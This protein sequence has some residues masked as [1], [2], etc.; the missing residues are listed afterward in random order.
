M[1]KLGGT[2]GSVVCCT[3]DGCNWNA[4]TAQNN[5]NYGD[6]TNSWFFIP[7]IVNWTPIIL[8]IIFGSLLLICPIILCCICC[9]CYRKQK[10]KQQK[11]TPPAPGPD[12]KPVYPPAPSPSFQPTPTKQIGV[13]PKPEPEKP[14]KISPAPPK[15]DPAK[16]DKKAD[17]LGD[18][19]KDIFAK[20]QGHWAQVWRNANDPNFKA[21]QSKSKSEYGV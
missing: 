20:V 7:D 18:K 17:P 6:I 4:T 11:K 9:C 10:K 21:P 19:T 15:K 2:S 12:K 13:K 16:V 1:V 3:E 14:A 8:G 5:Q